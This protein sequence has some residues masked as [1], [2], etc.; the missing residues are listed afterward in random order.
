MILLLRFFAPCFIV[1]WMLLWF[2]ISGLSSTFRSHMM[3][4]SFLVYLSVFAL[5]LLLMCCGIYGH[6]MAIEYH[7]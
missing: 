3:T 2:P 1:L 6:V 7:L 5:T 4:V